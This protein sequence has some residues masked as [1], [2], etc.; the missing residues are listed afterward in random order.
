MKKFLLLS[1]FAAGVLS[2]SANSLSFQYEGETVPQNGTV[3]FEGYQRNP[4]SSTKEEIFMNPEIFILS[5][6]DAKV[7]IKV[8]ANN[9]VQFC[10]GGQCEMNTEILKEGIQL[11]ANKPEDLQLD[12]SVVVEKDA[13]VDIPVIEVKIEAWYANDPANVVSMTLKMGGMNTG[14]EELTALQDNV[15][16]SG[17]YLVYDI[18]GN[19]LIDI[20]TLTGKQVIKENVSG[21]GSV[22]L[23][24][25]NKGIYVYRVSGKNGKNIRADKFIIK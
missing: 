13:D 10:I 1:M 7:N 9:T 21:S 11:Q 14:V 3:T 18:N 6:T 8:Q 22:S 12:S 20:Y 19:A 25:L 15:N 24:D 4:Y 17:N 23:L 5:D 16:I 2:V